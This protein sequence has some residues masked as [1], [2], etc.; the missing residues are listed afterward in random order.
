MLPITISG[1][2]VITKSESVAALPSKL[3]RGLKV[4]TF[5]WPGTRV[6]DD[7]LLMKVHEA[8]NSNKSPLIWCGYVENLE[9][10][11]SVCGKDRDIYAI[12]G[13]VGLFRPSEHVV[14]LLGR[15]YAEEIEKAIPSGSYMLAGLCLASRLA[16]E[17]ATILIQKGH[18]IPFLGFV[19]TDISTGHTWLNKYTRKVFNRVN[20]H[21]TRFRS[22]LNAIKN[23][24]P[25]FAKYIRNIP[26]ILK[27]S[28]GKEPAEF[29]LDVDKDIYKFRKDRDVM[30]EIKE[31]PGFI[32]LFYIRW[33]IFGFY[34]F[35]FFQRYWREIASDGI[36][37]DFV[38]G[39]AHQFPNWNAIIARMNKRI[40]E[41]GK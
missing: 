29:H 32:N 24:P 12:R 33:A 19:E 25:T 16:V 1:V 28:F 3:Y 15:Y 23:S 11:V 4:A 17:I 26:T 10:I 39:F 37:V 30:Y 21:G 38:N 34:Q 35:K 18:Q 31:Y 9:L 20:Y 8:N 2:F 14:S 41:T 5:D 6:S 36:K 22:S 27:D 7:S 40:L 13:P